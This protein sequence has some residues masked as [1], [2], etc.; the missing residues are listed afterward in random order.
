MS[1]ARRKAHVSLSRGSWAALCAGVLWSLTATVASAE[2]V[3]VFAAASL[4]DA[5]GELA[6]TFER[7]DPQDR[8]EL[9]FAGS[10]VLRTQIEQGAPADVFASADLAHAEALRKAG[11]LG[12]CRVFARNRLVVVAPAGP[13]RVRRLRDLARPGVRLVVAGASVPVGRYTAQVLGR[14]AA[15]GLFGDDFQDRVRANV[16]SEETNV[17][18]VLSKVA[19]GEADA[20]FVYATDVA[21]SD[22]VRPI[23]VPDR[24]NVVAEY[25]VGVVNGAS[26]A[27]PA[28]SFVDFVLG[29]EGQR[30]L[31]AYGFA[32]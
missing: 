13:G 1:R 8:V 26:A 20:G 11:L 15:S 31:S 29:P 6:A 7:T 10:Q 9:N 17:R 22:K 12:A 16:M 28:Q 27:G 2:T 3:R 21:R 19:L 24:Y 30:V 25:A 4:T 23:A 32:R 14:L 18:S 5:F